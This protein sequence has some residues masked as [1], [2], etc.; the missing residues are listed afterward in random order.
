MLGKAPVHAQGDGIGHHIIEEFRV[1]AQ[2]PVQF[3]RGDGLQ[4]MPQAQNLGGIQTAHL[5]APSA[6]GRRHTGQQLGGNQCQG[7]QELTGIQTD[8][9]PDQHQA[10]ANIQRQLAPD[11]DPVHTLLNPPG[12]DR[13]EGAHDNGQDN[14]QQLDTGHIH[15]QAH[16][17][18]N[19][20]AAAK[21]TENPDIAGERLAHG[22]LP[23]NMPGIFQAELGVLIA[24]AVDIAMLAE[25]VPE[26]LHFKQ[27]P[28]VAH[29]HPLVEPHPAVII[30][31]DQDI[32]QLGPGKDHHGQVRSGEGQT[33]AHF[34]GRDALRRGGPAYPDQRPGP[35]GDEPVQQGKAGTDGHGN[36]FGIA[37][38]D[39]G[40]DAPEII[41]VHLKGHG[42][43]FV[44]FQGACDFA[45][46]HGAVDSEFHSGLGAALLV[47]AHE[48]GPVSNGSGKG[49][50]EFHALNRVGEAADQRQGQHH[51]VAFLGL[52]HFHHA[53]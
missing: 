8:Q 43:G 34:A 45:G 41:R 11:V 18:E 15:G 7:Y 36:Q 38:P 20:R 37:L 10:V 21:K 47:A 42:Q 14:L 13:R 2:H 27:A 26:S 49:H 16:T 3:V 51:L 17:A 32:A 40:A 12:T 28:L 5:A 29:I 4:I 46:D 53:V 31:V 44:V 22:P 30:Q 6:V 35:Q 39:I 19:R 33:A 50:G 48:A 25:Q 52:D 24:G 9:Q 23:R 1:V